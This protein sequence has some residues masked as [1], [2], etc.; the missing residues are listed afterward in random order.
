MKILVNLFILCL[1]SAQINAQKVI[2]KEINTSADRIK[3]E[4]KFADDITIKTWDK[5]EVYLKAEVSINGGQFDDYYTLNIDN[6]SSV[7]NIESDY[8][9]LFDK[10]KKERGSNKKN[11]WD[12]CNNLDIDANYTL[13]LPKKSEFRIKSI[14]GDVASEDYQGD[15]EVDIIS[16]DIDIKKYSGD[17]VLKTV[18]GDIDVKVSKSKLRAETVT[19]MIYSDKDMNFDQGKNRMV[20]SKVTGSFGD[21]K[22]QLELKTVSGDI[23]I[24]KQ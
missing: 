19:G 16:G 3:A 7:L 9:D 4:F 13:Y 5:N 18:S 15:L 10:W 22:S 2:E 20:G 14:S 1:I 12:P 11:N 21:V 8:G 23:F 6:N 17:L 24:R